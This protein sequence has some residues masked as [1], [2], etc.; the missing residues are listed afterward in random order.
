MIPK[1][2]HYCW[3]GES[4]L[5]P[6]ALKCIESWKTYCPDYEIREWNEKN[7]DINYNIYVSEAYEAKKWA[8]VSDVAR[9]WALVNFG[10]IYMDTDCELL[11]PVD[12]F[13]NLEAVL[14]FE[15]SDRVSTAIM[16]CKK[17]FPLFTILLS[18]YDNRKFILP[19][20]SFD[21][22]TNV[23]TITNALLK[24][25]LKLN[26]QVQTVSNCML[27]PSEYFCPKDFH[28]NKLT[29]TSNT[30]V[31]H[32]FDA[33][34]WSEEDKNERNKKMRYISIFGNK[35]GNKINN[36]LHIL[37]TLGVLGVFKK[38]KSKF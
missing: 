31:I 23:T 1:I 25:G 4:P 10:G 17:D 14:G 32:H 15:E 36:F 29:I 34:W 8:F 7:F 5:P 9:L 11:K 24:H 28:T 2:I 33:S 16:G 30:H 27:Y 21:T 13:L 6:L 38:I 20:G 19:D 35:L 12:Q 26:N 18:A 3:F 37:K 22:T